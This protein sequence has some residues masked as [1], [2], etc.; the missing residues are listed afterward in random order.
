LPFLTKANYRV[1]KALEL[2]HG[3]LCGFIKPATPG[4]KTLFLL[5]VDDM[6]RYMWLVLLSANSDATKLIKQVQAEA[7]AESGKKLKVLRTDTGGEFTSSSFIDYC[8]ELGV[9]RH[10]T[11]PYSP[12]QNG[13]VERQNQ[14]VVGTTR[15]MLKAVGMPGKFWGEAFMTAVYTL[16]RSPTCNVEGRTSYE[17]WH[18]KKSSMHHL[19]VFGCTAYMKITR[20][21]LTKLDDRGLK[22][23]FISYKPGS[24]AYRL[25]DPISGRVQVSRDVV[26]DENTF[27]R[28]DNPDTEEQGAEPFTVE[29]LITEPD[30]GG[31]PGYGAPSTTPS[32]TSSPAVPPGTSASTPPL[33][34]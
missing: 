16:N 8:N 4:G 11:A 20:P 12:Q 15:S 7:E 31:A 29:Y 17:A 24:K 5:M 6:S 14:T 19:R 13:V 3:D 25:Y 21:R 22:T 10:L 32:H 33:V 27:W 18:G 23:V 30:E 28:W 26:F 1:G 2:V 9:R 34:Q